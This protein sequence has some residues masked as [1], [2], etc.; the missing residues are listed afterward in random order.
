MERKKS[1]AEVTVLWNGY[2]AISPLRGCP[3][4]S[5]EALAVRGPQEV[6]EGAWSATLVSF[7]FILHFFGGNHPHEASPKL[8]SARF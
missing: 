8:V 5:H 2:A 6:E 7:E 4:G 1:S 3:Y